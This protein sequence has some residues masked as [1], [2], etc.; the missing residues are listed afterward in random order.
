MGHSWTPENPMG[1][2]NP[3]NELGL[4]TANAGQQLTRARVVNVD[5]VATRDALPIPEGGVQGGAAEWL[6]P[7]P[8]S[9][10]EVHWTIALVPPW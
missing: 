3:R 7:D 10:L 1:M 6:F 5:G 9:Q 4:P 8:E 2:R